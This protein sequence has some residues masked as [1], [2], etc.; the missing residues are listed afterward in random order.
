[1]EQQPNSAGPRGPFAFSREHWAS[2]LLGGAIG[3]VAALAVMFAV[4]ASRIFPTASDQRIHA[5]LMSHPSLAIDME[6]KAQEQQGA[7]ILKAQQDAVDKLGVKAFFNPDVAYVTGPANAKNT[8]VEFFDYNCAHCRNTFPAVMK[9]YEAHKNDTRFAFID[10]PIFGPDSTE[11]AQVSI[12][13]RKQGDR[14]LA[15]HFALMSAPGAINQDILG[16]IL[17]KTGLNIDALN[18]AAANPSVNKDIAAADALAQEIQVDG[19]PFF[20]VNG[21][22]HSGEITDAEI[23]E[24]IKS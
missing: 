1:M 11:A 4:V 7:A 23:K 13:A 9:F 22:V 5:Y 2:A 10:F 14:F 16:Q 21:K 15:L 3:A 20:I 17:Q 6:N 19:T 24:L 18:A 8:F 12:A